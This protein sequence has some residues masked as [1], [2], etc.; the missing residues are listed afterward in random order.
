VE[1]SP[2]GMSYLNFCQDSRA[3]HFPWS[4]SPKTCI[5]WEP[6]KP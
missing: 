5:T 1:H 4:Y 6:W 2:E 3:C